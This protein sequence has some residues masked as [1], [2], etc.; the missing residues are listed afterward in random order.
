MIIKLSNKI[1]EA[2]TIPV[3]KELVSQLENLYKKAFLKLA[4]VYILDELQ[5]ATGKDKKFYSTL[6][7]KLYDRYPDV[8]SSSIPIDA[9]YLYELT[10]RMGRRNSDERSMQITAIPVDSVLQYL[11]SDSENPLKSFIRDKVSPKTAYNR[12][13]KYFDERDI[14]SLQIN[15]E[16]VKSSD[17]DA[18]AGLYHASLGILSVSFEAAFFTGV[19]ITNQEGRRLRISPRLSASSGKKPETII[20]YLEDE[21]REL[22]ISIRHELQHFYQSLFSKVFGV[23]DFKVGLPPQQVIKRHLGKK[24]DLSKMAHFSDPVEMQTDIQDEVDKFHSAYN[25]FR[26]ANKQTL[27]DNSSLENS[28]V[29]TMIKIFASS[30]LTS[31]EEKLAKN[32]K[33]YRYI[34][35][36]STVLR[37]IKSA[38]KNGE[39]YRYALRTLLNSVSGIFEEN[40]IMNKLKVVLKEDKNLISENLTKEEIRQIVR[41]ELEKMLKKTETKKDIAKITKEFV[42]KFYRELSFNSTHIIDQ[43]DV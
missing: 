8:Q 6:L 28:I 29:K 26:D 23:E 27:A 3:N 7:E 35:E 16:L 9:N 5:N 32:Y 42:K 30:K 31:E 43:I 25:Q 34:S 15:I 22:P 39:L 4:E 24:S 10:S 14:D 1:N 2:R 21:L 36:P 11:K 18:R 38:D 17:G 41:D 40:I 13:K 19:I 20:D 37:D 12:I 33:L